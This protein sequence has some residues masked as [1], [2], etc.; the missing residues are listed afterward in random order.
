MKPKLLLTL[1]LSLVFG[2]LSS[3]VPQGFNY[4]AIA[5]D[6]VS[7]N[8]ITDPVDV[9]IDILAGDATTIIREELHSAVDPDE[10]G[11]FS[12]VVGQGSWVSGLANFS[13]I[14][15]TVTPKYIKTLIWYGGEWKDMG[16]AQLW[17]VPYA[18]YSPS[19]NPWL[20]N[21]SSLYYSMGY[22]GIETDIPVAP[23]T[24]RYNDNTGITYPLYLQ[25]Q[26]NDWTATEKGVRSVA[27]C[28]A[29]GHLLF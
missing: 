16:P 11:L 19:T 17:S 27:F 8:P 15:W 1:L 26:S 28:C 21:G 12:L 14:D 5:R 18:M 2:L 24:V 25:N 23:L 29:A 13:D 10:H 3:Q 9:K 20:L 22:V 7:G 4:Q 6:G